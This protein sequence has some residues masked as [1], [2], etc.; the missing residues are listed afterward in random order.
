VVVRAN[1][2]VAAASAAHTWWAVDGDGRPEDAVDRALSM[3]A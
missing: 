2:L 3:L 1:V